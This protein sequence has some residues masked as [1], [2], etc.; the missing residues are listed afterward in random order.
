MNRTE[1]DL[2]AV[3]RE[4][5][6]QAD[7][8]GAPSSADLLAATLPD[9]PRESGQP[10]P[11]RV[12][13][14]LPPLAAAAA[15]AAAATTAVLIS[16]QGGDPSHSRAPQPGGQPTAGHTRA[17]RPAVVPH[18]SAPSSPA[19]A[20][21]ADILDDAASK[22]DSGQGWSP[23]APQDF[24]YVRTNQVTTWTSVSG[25]RPGRGRTA[26]GHTV[27]VPGCDHGQIVAN[28][29]TGTCTLNDVPHYLG[30]AP[31][32]PA[33]WDAYLEQLAPGTKAAHAQGKIIVEVLHQ[34]LVAPTAAAAL[35]RYTESCPG[36][37]TL[38]VHPVRGE[39]L[40]GVTCT[41]MTNGSYGLAFDAASHEF[42]G[43][44]VVSGSGRQDFPAE[45]VRRT[46]IVPAIGRRP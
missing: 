3:L 33:K 26:D 40:I 8:H 32:A 43:F 1:N 10:A 30:D 16:P 25:T 46:G 39:K 18:S 45:I 15:V 7:R 6:Q 31:T 35:L 22:L 37:H 13:R 28:G 4:F 20:S 19:P 38:T 9:R 14:W 5:E 23:P 27:S 29:E 34:D 42:V 2:R 21:A 41:S 24:F 36:L 12:R 11:R 44:V 17:H